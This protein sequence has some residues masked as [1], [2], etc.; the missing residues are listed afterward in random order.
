MHHIRHGEYKLKHTYVSQEIQIYSIK[1]HVKL[2]KDGNM[3]KEY[4]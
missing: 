3:E 2:D 4:N 1:Y